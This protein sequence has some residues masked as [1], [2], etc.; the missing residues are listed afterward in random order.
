MNIIYGPFDNAIFLDGAGG[1][2]TFVDHNSIWLTGELGSTG[3]NL[4]NASGI[5]YRNNIVYGDNDSTGLD[6][7][8]VSFGSSGDCGG[9]A[10]QNNVNLNHN[11]ICKEV[12]TEC[13][14]YCAGGG[15]L[16]DVSDDPNFQDEHLCIT[17]VANALINAGIDVGYD[18]VD[19]DPDVE[20]YN[21]SA[22][23]VGARESGVSRMYG[24]VTSP[25]C[26]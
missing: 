25:A 2:A 6:L 8:T 21:G 3:V 26:P 16:C 22:P 1:T 24:G 18:M 13:A 17:P 5:C 4:Q 10:T 11:T 9:A 23:E 14:D 15:I 20:K 12:N 7:D 19:D